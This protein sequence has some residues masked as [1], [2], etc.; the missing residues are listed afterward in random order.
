MRDPV[1]IIVAMTIGAVFSVVETR[2]LTIGLSR[3][4]RLHELKQIGTL[5][6]PIGLERAIVLHSIFDDKANVQ[7]YKARLG[8]RSRAF[9]RALDVASGTMRSAG[10]GKTID[11]FKNKFLLGHDERN[12]CRIH[13]QRLDLSGTPGRSHKTRGRGASKSQLENRA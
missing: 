6:D 7:K 1:V 10:A 11:E 9:G 4:A 5:T 3:A 2:D 12:R 8:E 13:R